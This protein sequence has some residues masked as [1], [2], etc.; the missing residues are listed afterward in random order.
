MGTRLGKAGDT[1]GKGIYRTGSR[2]AWFS[3]GVLL[4]M[5]FFTFSDVFGRYLLN[6]PIA[7]S[8]DVGEIMVVTLAFLGVAYTQVQRGHVRV[9][10]LISRLSRHTQA[11]L[12]TITSFLSAGIFG[13]IGWE[14]GVRA[15]G[16]MVSREP[17]VLSPT[18]QIPE[19]PFMLL[20]AIGLVILCL[21]LLVNFFRSL[22]EVAM[23]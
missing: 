6:K 19:A 5:M 8:I 22:G 12:E 15:V 7:G 9:E 14:V 3:A 13:F 18:L 17:D 20:A 2:I 4:L 21:V 1:I 11:I 23:R 16:I 10:I